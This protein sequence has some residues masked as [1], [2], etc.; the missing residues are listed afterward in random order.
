MQTVCNTYWDAGKGNL[1]AQN[2]SC[3]AFGG[4]DS[5][6]DPAEGTYSDPA[7]P[8]SWWG[9]AGCPLSKNPIPALGPSGLAS[10]T[11]TPKL[12]PT[13]MLI[14]NTRTHIRIYVMPYSVE[15]KCQWFCAGGELM[16][17]RI[18]LGVYSQVYVSVVVHWA[19]VWES[20]HS[21]FTK[22]VSQRCFL[23]GHRPAGLPLS[24]CSRCVNDVIA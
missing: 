19:E 20:I 5:A 23:C 12:V 11:P 13:P 15:V 6:Q 2:T 7:K 9:G 1:T 14:I 10:S 16:L 4:R 24:L 22:S 8:R 21:V 18:R 17:M 3:D